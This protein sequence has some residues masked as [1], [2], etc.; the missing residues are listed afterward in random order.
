ME[1]GGLAK[2]A[3]PGGLAKQ[4]PSSCEDLMAQNGGGEI[5]GVC[6]LQCL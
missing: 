6:V 5:D 1:A 4:A 2:Q 3:Q